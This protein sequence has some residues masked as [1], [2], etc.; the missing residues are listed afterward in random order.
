M[1]GLLNG[2]LDRG[3]AEVHRD[4]RGRGSGEWQGVQAMRST[5]SIG[6]ALVLVISTGQAQDAPSTKRPEVPKSAVASGSQAQKAGTTKRAEASKS[7]TASRSH[8]QEAPSK[9]RQE[10]LK[11]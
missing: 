2:W 6:L 1:A 3:R 8:A 4:E 10:A 5:G 7:A 9:E 11:S